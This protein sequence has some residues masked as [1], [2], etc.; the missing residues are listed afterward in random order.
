MKPLVHGQTCW[1]TQNQGDTHPLE[2]VEPNRPQTQLKDDLQVVEMK[3][4][5][6]A[7]RD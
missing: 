7:W 6:W 4:L 2:H 1:P 5:V 3:M